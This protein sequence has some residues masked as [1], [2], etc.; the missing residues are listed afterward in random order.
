[1]LIGPEGT[2]GTYMGNVFFADAG[3]TLGKAY[4]GNLDAACILGDA[5]AAHVVHGGRENRI[6][7]GAGGASWIPPLTLAG[8]GL[9][10]T[11]QPHPPAADEGE[12]GEIRWVED[13]EASALY[14]KTARGWK[15]ARFE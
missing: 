10:L 1:M 9:R 2:H 3:H 7:S 8:T 14:L 11:P 6:P 5:A 13:G 15:R 12:P 4:D